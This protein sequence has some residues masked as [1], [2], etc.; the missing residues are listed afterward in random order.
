MSEIKTVP[1]ESP[2]V[3]LRGHDFADGT[4]GGKVATVSIPTTYIEYT[5]ATYKYFCEAAVGSAKSDAAWQVARKT[6]ADNTIIYAG[7]GAADQQAT[8]LATVT[9]LTYALGD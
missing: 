8:N 9:N 4:K 7:T 6:L 3:Y 1:T 2:F 5:D